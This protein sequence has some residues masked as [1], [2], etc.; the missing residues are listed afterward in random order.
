MP[1]YEFQC[2]SHGPFEAMRP[3]ARFA[4]PCD[5]PQCGAP[6]PRILLTAPRLASMEGR[7]RKAHAMNE[8]SAHQPR[9]SSSGVG[10]VHG[11]GCGCG[12]AGGKKGGA[13][14][15][16]DGAKTFPSRRPWMISH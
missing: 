9:L 8:R 5:C 2:P 12:S 1:I 7:A 14:R 6:A 16:A 13:T 11:P 10:H 4:D 15:T 3:M